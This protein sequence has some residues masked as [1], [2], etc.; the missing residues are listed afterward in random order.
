MV[1]PLVL[2]V[3][4]ARRASL[5]AWGSLV[6]PALFGTQALPEPQA[7]LVGSRRVRPASRRMETR[8]VLVLGQQEAP[9][10][11]SETRA[12]PQRQVF[13]RQ[14]LAVREVLGVELFLRAV[15]LGSR[16]GSRLV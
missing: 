12:S 6:V 9:R 8:V 10:L 5:V 7:L 1:A 15:V 2:A 4:E 3:W 16:A 14:L 13:A 11:G